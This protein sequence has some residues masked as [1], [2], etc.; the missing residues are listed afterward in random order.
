MSDQAIK[1]EADPEEE[2]E[3][4]CEGWPG[5]SYIAMFCFRTILPGHDPESEGE[6][7]VARS[8]GLR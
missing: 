7:G 8:Q 1:D 3:V 5:C 2:G 4:H 6:A